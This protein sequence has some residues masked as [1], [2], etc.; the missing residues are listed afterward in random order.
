MEAEGSK[1]ALA[2]TWIDGPG[3]DA[4]RSAAG[5]RINTVDLQCWK[6]RK[7]CV[8]AFAFM[9]PKISAGKWLAPSRQSLHAAQRHWIVTE[10][11]AKTIIA[12]PEDRAPGNRLEIDLAGRSATIFG[13][14]TPLGHAG[15][16]RGGLPD[17]PALTRASPPRARCPEGLSS[18][19]DT[20]AAPSSPA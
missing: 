16:G 2:G 7:A 14:D 13:G 1:V 6:E 17:D 3:S 15:R 8:E 4:T 18:T 5:F 20:A 9:M 11:T 12:V 10:W 19:P